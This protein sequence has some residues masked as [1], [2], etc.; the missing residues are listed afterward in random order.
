[1]CGA[2]ANDGA[3]ERLIGQAEDIVKILCRILWVAPR[4]W[5]SER[6]DCAAIAKEVADGVGE[7]CRAGKGPYH[8]K[9]GV[10]RQLFD[11]VLH[12][13]VTEVGHVVPKFLAPG[14]HYLRHDAGEVGVNYAAVQ[15]PDGALGDEIDDG[16][17]APYHVILSLSYHNVRR[18]NL[19]P[20]PRSRYP[21][22]FTGAQKT[23]AKHRCRGRS[24]ITL[25]SIHPKASVPC[26]AFECVRARTPLTGC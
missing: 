22:G 5:S 21:A 4:V 7:L 8:Q 26:R 12:P 1:M 9:V 2:L 14:C 11:D 3:Q 18:H 6:R 13:R 24:Q 17:P 16:N 15:P 23:E 10:R 19:P 25:C 20:S